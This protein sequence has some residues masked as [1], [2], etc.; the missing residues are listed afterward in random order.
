[1]NIAIVDDQKEQQTIIQNKLKGINKYQFESYSFSSVF[2]MN[3]SKI[4]FNLILL[5]I[6]MPEMNGLTYAKENVDQNIVFITGYSKYMKSA[7]GP[8]V[9]GFIEKTDSLEYFQQVIIDSLDRISQNHF[10]HIKTSDGNFSICV[11]HIIYV[12]YVRRKTLCLKLKDKEYI[13]SGYS[14]KEFSELLGSMFMFCD[15][16]IIFNTQKVIGIT[17]HKLILQD[18]SHKIGISSRRLN[19]VKNNYYKRVHKD[20]DN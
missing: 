15:R 14:L 6:D 20:Y 13:V 18:V 16:D 2:E 9:Y 4:H 8:N 7:F 11:D 1:M 12:Q 19:M 5:D 3:E 17:S 10:I